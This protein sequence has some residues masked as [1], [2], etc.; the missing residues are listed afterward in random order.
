MPIRLSGLNSGLDT[1]SIVKELVSAYSKKTETYTKA[2]TKLSWKQDT[3]KSLNSKIY[4]LYTNVYDMTLTSGYSARKATSSDNT[5]ATVK[6]SNGAVNGTQKLN[7]LSTAD[8]GY[9]T[10]GKLTLTDDGK[11]TNK[12][13]ITGDTKLK[14][15]GYTGPDTQFQITTLDEKGNEKKTLI[16][17]TKASTLSEIQKEMGKL[18]LN[19][20]L[21]S[22]NSRLFV[23]AKESGK[24]ADFKIEAI[25][26]SEGG[27]AT[28]DRDSLNMLS[29]LGLNTS[30][31]TIVD[32]RN[33]IMAN[34]NEPLTADSTMADIN[35]AG[36]AT[37]F[38]I[39]TKDE[40]GVEVT[41]E[42]NITEDKKIGDIISE[43]NSYGVNAS[44]D[45]ENKRIRIDSTDSF[46]IK[47]KMDPSDP[48]GIICDE[49][50]A[51]AL[52]R[53]G[54]NGVETTY[55]AA[56]KIDGK[57]SEIILNGTTYTG[58]G[59]S[60]TINGLSIDV[61]GITGPGDENAIKLT[62]STDTQEIYDKIKSF[63]SEYNSI[64]NEMTSMYN[65]DSSKGYEPL[66][67][68]EKD[69]MS[70]T[71][72]E[73]WETKIKDSL[74]R[75]DSTLDGV[76]S[77]MINSMSQSYEVNGKS[78][79]FATLGIETLG[80]LKAPKNEQNAFHIAGD[81]DDENSK[82]EPDKLMAAIT[83]DPDNVIEFMKKVSSELYSQLDTKMK[84][85]SS[86][87]S[88]YKV[89]NDKEMDKQYSD[90]TTT[91]K[92]WE[93]KVSTKEDYYYKKF[94]AMETALAKMQSQTSSLS[95]LFGSN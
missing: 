29:T 60:F 63:L 24:D 43:L 72:V 21:D 56:N 83:A 37:S 32:G 91:I 85:N 1:D 92:N 33:M 25:S 2:Q 54:L 39:K 3:W 16:S 4:K 34:I 23:S 71:E 15:L 46:E 27:V 10:G 20:N 75:R 38:Y 13:G 95:G 55:E 52:T 47:S 65:A 14:D 17:V 5:K 70:D 90:Y 22:G 18:G 68:E 87:S 66:T 61:Q 62:V 86:M 44:L 6:A 49:D 80:Y 57:D 53:L 81:E 48:E 19:V 77:V 69:A 78:M 41:N 45:T 79:S 35:Y 31:R 76:M 74:L 59:N 40:N 51:E 42:I 67:D 9:M 12:D 28:A 11:Q 73:K 88:I 50:S 93:T 89:Y 58:K 82:S 7:V 84:E 64:I 30:A 8:T 36:G 26:S 94:T